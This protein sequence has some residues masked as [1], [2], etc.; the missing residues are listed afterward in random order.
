MAVLRL[1]VHDT[2]MRSA[3]VG[4]PLYLSTAIAYAAIFLMKV[5]SE[6]KA[7]RFNINF[8]DVCSVLEETVA[9][10]NESRDYVRH[11]SHHLGKGLSR[12]LVKFKEREAAYQQQLAQPDQQAYSEE[13]GAGGF[14]GWNGE[15]NQWQDWMLSEPD[16]TGQFGLES[17]DYYPLGLLDVLGSQ[18][19]GWL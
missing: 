8:A 4:V 6:W 10:L 13:Q 19:P 16:V 1:I 5:Q 14:S 12:M 2:D 15:E 3:V 7:A 18:M 17:L 11:V 9:L